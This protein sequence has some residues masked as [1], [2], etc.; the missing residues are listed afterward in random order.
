[1]L[2]EIAFYFYNKI[3]I[4]W[5]IILERETWD[6]L[7]VCCSL[8]CWR[9]LGYHHIE[10]EISLLSL[11][12]IYYFYFCCVLLVSGS[13][14]NILVSICIAHLSLSL[15]LSCK[16]VNDGTAVLYTLSN[17][18]QSWNGDIRHKLVRQSKLPNYTRK[19]TSS[20]SAH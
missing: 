18:T 1:M 6:I 11:S 15:S 8:D 7:L 19:S 3:L 16:K 12:V 2:Q 10:Y 9:P 13:P 17:T 5:C 4:H 14:V 20:R